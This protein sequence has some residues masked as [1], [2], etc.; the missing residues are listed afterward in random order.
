MNIEIVRAKHSK[1]LMDLKK[2]KREEMK[3]AKR[4]SSAIH[5]P[6]LEN[7]KCLRTNTHSEWRQTHTARDL[8]SIVRRRSDV[9][10]AKTQAHR[11]YTLSHLALL[12]LFAP[13]WTTI[14]LLLVARWDECV[15]WR[16]EELRRDRK[17]TCGMNNPSFCC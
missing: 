4:S 15:P 16:N 10:W 13:A 17:T 2:E 14:S 7:T 6:T 1:V 3:I 8:T 5:W 11:F 12:L 9:N